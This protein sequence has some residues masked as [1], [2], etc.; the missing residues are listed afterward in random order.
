MEVLTIDAIYGMSQLRQIKFDAR[1]ILIR[2]STVIG[3]VCDEI[4]GKY[5]R[6]WIHQ[7]LNYSSF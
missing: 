6:S 4:V 3:Q 2:N 7:M 5:H 1:E